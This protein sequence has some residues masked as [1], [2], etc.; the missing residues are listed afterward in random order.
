MS[1]PQGWGRA[2]DLEDS[3]NPFVWQHRGDPDL[4]VKVW[5]ADDAAGFNVPAGME[6]NIE[7]LFMY[8]DTIDTLNKQEAVNEAR[9]AAIDWMEEHPYNPDPNP[10]RFPTSRADVDDVPT[11]RLQELLKYT[12]KAAHCPR[13]G[14][15]NYIVFEDFQNQQTDCR[16]CGFSMEY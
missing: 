2:R 5:V 6:K 16:N 13:C 11:E 7:S 9:S 15:T 4:Q 10:K 3:D 8:S 12:L 1:S 14:R